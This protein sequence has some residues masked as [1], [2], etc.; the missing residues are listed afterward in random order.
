MY[1]G[2]IVLIINIINIK[3]AEPVRVNKYITNI[4]LPEKIGHT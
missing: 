3:N 1:A 4:Y 2:M